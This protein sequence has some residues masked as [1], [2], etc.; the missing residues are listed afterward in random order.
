[1]QAAMM[2]FLVDRD[3]MP[4][5]EKQF[6]DLRTR[7][8][9]LEQASG[10][11]APVIQTERTPLAVISTVVGSAVAIIAVMVP[12]GI[13]LDNKIGSIQKDYNDLSQRVVKLDSA[14]KALNS[15][16][17][18]QTQKLVQDLLASAKSANS[19]NLSVKATLAAASLTSSLRASKTPA[20]P[21]FF[22]SSIDALNALPA[23]LGASTFQAR[24]AL[25][26]YRSAIVSLPN[27]SA[28]HLTAAHDQECM[29][30]GK[31][32]PNHLVNGSAVLDHLNLISNNNCFLRLDNVRW[33][34]VAFVNMRIRYYG[35]DL[36][37]QN[38]LFVNCTFEIT[39]APKNSPRAQQL[40]DYAALQGSKLSFAGM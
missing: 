5:N 38:V 16:Q 32:Y 37:L 27:Q 31:D 12:F 4:Y 7:V 34:N 36:D 26:D 8:R 6:N 30:H 39:P 23:T 2:E 17:N 24:L 11:G 10:V 15:Q 13:H 3:T 1:M 19:P 9:E 21:E 18:N 28:M 25:A 33:H 40:V 35:G 29:P 14:V 20:P 22:R